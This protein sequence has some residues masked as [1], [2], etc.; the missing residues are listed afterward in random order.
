MKQRNPCIFPS[1]NKP[2]HVTC[3]G[4][5]QVFSVDSPTGNLKNNSCGFI[6]V[7]FDYITH[8]AVG[9]KRQG[10]AKKGIASVH[11]HFQR[12]LGVHEL[13]QHHQKLALIRRRRHLI[14]AITFKITYIIGGHHAR[15]VCVCFLAHDLQQISS[16]Y[17]DEYRSRKGSFNICVSN[18]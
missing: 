5:I 18:N 2:F 4:K 17:T 8:L 3:I 9:G 12:I 13:Q 16:S 11:T 6:I 15:H 10:S 7:G 1:S 14:P